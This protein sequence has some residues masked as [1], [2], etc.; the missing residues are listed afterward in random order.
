MF[1][2]RV[3]GIARGSAVLMAIALSAWSFPQNAQAEQRKFQLCLNPHSG[4]IAAK[5]KCL[6]YETLV[7]AQA[8]SAMVAESDQISVKS[9]PQGP[10]GDKGD[11]GDRGPA[12][13]TGPKGETGPAGPR[14][15][16]GLTGLKGETGS[17]GPQ[18]LK[19]STG[20]TGP[21]GPK[22]A[23]GA[24]GPQGPQ[25]PAGMS[26]YEIMVSSYAIGS[27]LSGNHRSY[28]SDGKM[29]IGGGAY[30]SRNVAKMFLQSSTPFV[31]NNRFGWS[32]RYLNSSEGKVE[33]QVWA[34]C[35]KM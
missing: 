31:E 8:L 26:G 2:G 29:I 5:R 11:K 15:A 35:A 28:C 32:A 1:Q 13:A 9:G 7:D 12:G 10:K 27:G 21:Q 22:G 33:F 24:V 25:G 3:T 20:A 16:T 6:W 17:T 18:G 30:A 14:G 19:G 23:T 4:N 34:I